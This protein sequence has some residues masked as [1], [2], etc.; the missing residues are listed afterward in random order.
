L[1][2]N[3]NRPL[4]SQFIHLIDLGK[5]HTLGSIAPLNAEVQGC[6]HGFARTPPAPPLL[7][8]F[9]PITC[10]PTYILQKV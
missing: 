7:I 5:K 8:A 4:K 3:S 6:T 9:L 1:F 2:L 10:T